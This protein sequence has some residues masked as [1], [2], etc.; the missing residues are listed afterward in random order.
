MAAAVRR[1]VLSRY[2]DY[3]F[4]LLLCLSELNSLYEYV[5]KFFLTQ[6]FIYLSM[7]LCTQ[8]IYSGENNYGSGG[9][10]VSSFAIH[11]VSLFPFNMFKRIKCA[12]RIC[13]QI[14]SNTY[15]YLSMNVFLHAELIYLTVVGRGGFW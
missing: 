8:L 14:F 1:W 15:I 7:V 3:R 10:K 4:F 13:F 5:F 11:W 2:I 12:L 6:I 9:S